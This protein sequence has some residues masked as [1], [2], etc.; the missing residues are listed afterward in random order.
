[1]GPGPSEG[2]E[3]H[4]GLSAPLP[5]TYLLAYDAEYRGCRQLADW[6]RR[7]DRDGLVVT[8]PFEN[9]E[10]VRVAPELA[11]MP[12]AG[13]VHGFDTRTREIRTGA[14]LL[15][16][17]FRRLPHWRWLAPLATLPPVASMLFAILRPK[18]K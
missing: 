17:L 1:M 2:S 15:A 9:A 3:N 4:S 16:S 18:I 14:G 8:F 11:G 7:R 5:A 12:Q 13:Q 10:L 6:I